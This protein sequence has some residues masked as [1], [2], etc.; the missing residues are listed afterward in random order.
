M[1]AKQFKEWQAYSQLEPFGPP[2]AYWR[3]GLTVSMVANV[4]RTKSTQKAFTPEDFM[5]STMTA[6]DEREQDLGDRFVEACQEQ[7]AIEHQRE[8]KRR[9]RT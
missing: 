2:A 3:T 6:Q 5:P 9:G 4:N 7:A 1:S 8:R